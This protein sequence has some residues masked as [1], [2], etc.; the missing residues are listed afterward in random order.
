[1][2][3]IKSFVQNFFTTPDRIKPGIYHFQAPPQDPH[4]YRLHLRVEANGQGIMIVNAAT[5][6]HLNQTATE[7]GYHLIQETPEAMVADQISSRYHVEREQA[8]KDYQDFKGRIETI[9]TTPD[10]DPVSFLD[11]DREA[12]YTGQISA[13]YRLDCALTYRLPPDEDPRYAPT[14]LVTRELTTQEWLTIIDKAW[15]AG[16]PHLVFTGGEP[17]LRDDLVEMIH[18][19][20]EN[21]QV[22]GLLTD[23]LRF[24]DS[25]YL[26][27]LLNTG[28]DHVMI[29]WDK[30]HP[31]QW[32]ALKNTIREDLFVAVHL[33]VSEMTVD[34][35]E[36]TLRR[37]A[38]AGISGLSLSA[39]SPEYN[40]NLQS[41]RDLAAHLQLELTWNLPVPY[42]SQNPVTLEIPD[43]ELVARAGQAWLYIEPDGDVLPTQGESHVIGNIVTQ[44]FAEISA[45]LAAEK[46]PQ[47]SGR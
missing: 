32:E 7:M 19:A 27:S 17:T 36:E 16:I 3:A 31:E 11:F 5:I 33:T 6:L 41:A 44:S 12:P 25:E 23:G 21:G 1:M 26:Q 20:E 47:P 9:I 46:T 39:A 35:L 30:R 2:S 28:L 40:Q 14:K 24:V 22:T 29:I 18:K 15:Q 38:E 45:T 42:S 43:Q 4:N 34:D 13:P 10:L 37:L 8:L